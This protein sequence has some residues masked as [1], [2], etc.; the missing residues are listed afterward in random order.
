MHKATRKRSRLSIEQLER[1]EDI[2]Q[3]GEKL[4]SE[5]VHQLSQSVDLD[6]KTIRIWFNNRKA[7]HN[8][9][10]PPQDNHIVLKE[11][12]NN[13]V[14]DESSFIDSELYTNKKL[15]NGSVFSTS[16]ML[17]SIPR[18]TIYDTKKMETTF[19]EYFSD[20]INTIEKNNKENTGGLNLWINKKDYPFDARDGIRKKRVLFNLGKRLNENY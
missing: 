8:R 13:P 15:G 7:K 16:G 2:F 1:L 4:T 10:N 14:E 6:P 20:Y 5:F 9:L 3:N 12:S 11:I 18:N 17:G 19:K